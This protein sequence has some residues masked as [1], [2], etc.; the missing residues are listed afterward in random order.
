MTWDNEV[1]NKTELY[2]S[3]TLIA[4]NLTQKESQSTFLRT[5][6]QIVREDTIVDTTFGNSSRHKDDKPSRWVKYIA[7]IRLC[8]RNGCTAPS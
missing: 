2:T 4:E 5:N 3:T 6:K 7:S 1:G 8:I